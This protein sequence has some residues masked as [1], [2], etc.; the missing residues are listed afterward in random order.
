MY[1]FK[2]AQL[3]EWM[4]WCQWDSIRPCVGL[5]CFRFAQLRRM[6]WCQ[7]DLM[8]PCVG[9]YRFKFAQLKD[10]V[11][12]MSHACDLWPPFQEP[13]VSVPHSADSFEADQ[14]GFRLKGRI[15]AH[16]QYEHT[17]AYDKKAKSFSAWL[18]AWKS[19]L[20]QVFISKTIL[21]ILFMMISNCNERRCNNFN[22]IADHLSG[23]VCIVSYIMI[24][25]AITFCWSLP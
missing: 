9:L 1:C 12:P 15:S 21:F 4:A 8:K 6:A 13:T 20:Y 14:G 7:W 2:F 10:G 5:Y 16:F 11:T 25:S 24:S 23:L 17:P 18:V 3:R 19:F 22:S